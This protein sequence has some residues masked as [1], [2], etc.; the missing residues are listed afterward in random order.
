MARS[1][2]TSGPSLFLGPPVQGGLSALRADWRVVSYRTLQPFR[3]G[4]R[5]VSRSIPLT[6]GRLSKRKCVCQDSFT[7]RAPE[8]FIR[9]PLAARALSNQ[10]PIWSL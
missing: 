8:I 1:S 10:R 5:G 3:R 4:C 2:Q 7:A 9:T 6:Q